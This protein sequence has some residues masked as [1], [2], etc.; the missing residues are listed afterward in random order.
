MT[1][2]GKA[3]G[4]F[5]RAGHLDPRQ[6]FRSQRIW[7]FFAHGSKNEPNRSSS[8]GNVK[9]RWRMWSPTNADNVSLALD[10]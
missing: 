1:H 7:A 4:L 8:L 10:A 5:F 9:L 2:G 3:G 6:F